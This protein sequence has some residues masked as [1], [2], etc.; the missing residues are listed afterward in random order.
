M[1]HYFSFIWD[2]FAEILIFYRGAWTF[3]SIF[4]RHLRLAG[5]PSKWC[6]HLALSWHTPNSCIQL[7]ETIELR[8]FKVKYD[9]KLICPVGSLFLFGS[10]PPCTGQIGIW[11]CACRDWLLS[12]ASK[13]TDLGLIFQ[14]HWVHIKLDFPASPLVGTLNG[15]KCRETPWKVRFVLVSLGVKFLRSLFAQVDSRIT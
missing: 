13:P 9:L 1:F 8:Q 7:V 5:F 2:D 11:C 6:I 12:P 4:Q 3:R 15:W 10:S 14:V